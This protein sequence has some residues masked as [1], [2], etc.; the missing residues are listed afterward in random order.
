MAT[1]KAAA[2][3]LA[4]ATLVPAGVWW[5]LA[6]V[7]GALV[8]LWAM[9]GVP[10]FYLLKRVVLLCPF[11][12]LSL[13]LFPFL[14]AGDAVGAARVGPWTFTVTRQGL[15]LA[16]NLA[17]KFTL[18]VLLLG[19]LFS[20]TRFQHFLYALRRFRVP[21]AL[22]M[23]LG[24]LYRYLYVIGDEGERMLRAR[25]ARSGGRRGRPVWR[26]TAGL[27][28]VLFLRSYLRSER[29]YW[30]MLARGF[31]GE[32]VL[33]DRLRWRTVDRVFAALGLVTAT[34]I[35]VGWMV[36]R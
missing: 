34:A 19:L 13:V 23:Q 35:T 1:T 16:G 32:A 25:D 14:Y 4:A 26:A 33:L 15:E 12:I 21:P 2:T 31:A 30:A 8:V 22:V 36:A 10:A 3:T 5:P 9:S 11:M 18:A 7:G 17:A 6:A 27:I 24:F 28:G 20:V 29:I